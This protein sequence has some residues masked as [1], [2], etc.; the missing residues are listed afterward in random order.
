ML[1]NFNEV[2]LG[3]LVYFLGLMS[4]LSNRKHL[5]SMLLSLEF[6]V[7][8]SFLLMVR[9]VG[10]S[11]GEESFLLFFL[12]MVVCEGSLGLSI[13]VLVI[14]SHGND[15]FSSMKLLEC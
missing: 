13:L 10:G 9:L 12:T 4:F 8:G 5:L 14:R 7:L 15:Y 6:M 11:L 1:I 3:I 2:L